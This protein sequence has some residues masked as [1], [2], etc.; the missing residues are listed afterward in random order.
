LLLWRWTRKLNAWGVL[1]AFCVLAVG[2]AALWNDRENAWEHAEQSG[3]NLLLAMRSDIF[4]TL[5]LY[6]LSLNGVA[7]G[8]RLPGI[9]DIDPKLRHALLFDRAA[10]AEYLGSLLVLN[11]AG[12]IIYDSASPVPR[13]ANL[14]DRDYFRV[15]RDNPDAGLYLSVPYKSRLRAGDESIAI[16]RRLSNPDGSFAGVVM[17]AIRL[18]YFR[19]RFHQLQLDPESTIILFRDDGVLLMRTPYNEADIGRDMSSSANV[20]R[21]RSEGAGHFAGTSAIDG[22]ERLYSFSSVNG[23]P[24]ILAMAASTH[25]LMSPWRQRALVLAPITLLLCCAILALTV[26]F[27]RELQARRIAEAELALQARTDALTGLAN[28]RCFDQN[29]Q[30]EWRAAYRD[31]APLAL[32][33]IDVDNFKAY[34]DHYGHPV[35]DTLLVRLAGLI[36][37]NSGRPRD[38]SA[39]YGGEEFTVLLPDTTLKN[40]LVVA[41]QIRQAVADSRIAHSGTEAGIVTI[42]VGLAAM[43]PDHDEPAATLISRADAALYRAKILGRNRCETG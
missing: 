42:S 30:K 12:D 29:L 27:Q 14:A 1:I 38:F 25:E 13:Q 35:G 37:A 10:T 4:R 20:R 5:T 19:D 15:H 31:R 11:T 24:L 40:G 26:M 28:R 34:N 3:N 18:A 9:Q 33:F 23:L 16:S 7:D 39:R 2:G 22:I 21:F 36:D 32:L 6:D 17:G 8:L 43:V 41:D